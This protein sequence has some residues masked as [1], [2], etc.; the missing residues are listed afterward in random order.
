MLLGNLLIPDSD[1]SGRT[2]DNKMTSIK[3]IH[4]FL[5]FFKLKRNSK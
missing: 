4:Q 5:L 1:Q 3:K 2:T